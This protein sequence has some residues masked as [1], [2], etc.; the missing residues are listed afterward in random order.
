MIVIAI[1]VCVALKHQYIFFRRYQ[2]NNIRSIAESWKNLLEKNLQRE[3]I[4]NYVHQHF[5]ATKM[6]QQYIQLVR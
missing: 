1:F 3:S 6:M 5:N 4:I 2:P